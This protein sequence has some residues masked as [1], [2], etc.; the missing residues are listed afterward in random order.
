[1]TC[2]EMCELELVG[3]AVFLLEQTGSLLSQGTDSVDIGALTPKVKPN[4]HCDTCKILNNQSVTQEGQVACML[5]LLLSE[6]YSDG[7]NLRHQSESKNGKGKGLLEIAD[8]DR[9]ET[10]NKIVYRHLSWTLEGSLFEI[11]SENC[12]RRKCLTP[13]LWFQIFTALCCYSIF[14]SILIDVQ[15]CTAITDGGFRAGIAAR[16]ESAYKALVSVFIWATKSDLL[17]EWY[18]PAGREDSLNTAKELSKKSFDTL[19]QLVQRDQ[20]ENRGIK[21][22]KDFLM[23]L[24]SGFYNDGTYNGFY[25]QRFGLKES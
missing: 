16:I 21:S 2:D 8:S 9:H 22:S 23:G 14:K 10:M 18:L 12:C 6:V 11:F 20:W 5:C 7:S 19:C 17:V 4:L 25:I 13:E 1:M 3:L 24:G 15:T